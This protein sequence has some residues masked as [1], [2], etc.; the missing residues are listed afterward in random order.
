M[1]GK[2]SNNSRRRDPRIV[3]ESYPTNSP[4]R[5]VQRIYIGGL[6][7]SKKKYFCLETIFIH[8]INM[9]EGVG[10]DSRHEIGHADIQVG[11]YMFFLNAF[12]CHYMCT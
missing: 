11:S 8:G 3:S 10:E 2:L 6:T 12:G 9:R 5:I 1:L 4:R 7:T